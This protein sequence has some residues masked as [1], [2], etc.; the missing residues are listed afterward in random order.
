M[1]NPNIVYI[2]FD[3]LGYGDISYLNP[4]SKIQTPNMDRLSSEGMCSTDVHSCSAVCSPS[5]YGVLT[6][7]YCWRTRL[8]NG[9]LNGYSEPLI[10]PERLT[11]ASLLKQHGYH[12]ACIG[13]WHVGL[14]WTRK[15]GV[16][17]LEDYRLGW[18]RGEAI[19]FTQPFTGGP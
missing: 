18:D 13:K 10:E 19:D 6:G 12:T 14:N 15:K 3:D 9:V 4:E 1:S 7:R 5:R 2:F 17:N 16:Q 11:V 8:Q